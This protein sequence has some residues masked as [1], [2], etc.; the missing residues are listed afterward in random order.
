MTGGTAYRLPA[1]APVTSPILVHGIERFL[2]R[3][4]ELC[5]Y[6]I[7]QGAL[8]SLLLNW[9]YLWISFENGMLCGWIGVGQVT[10]D[11]LFQMTEKKFHFSIT[12]SVLSS[13][14]NVR[15]KVFRFMFT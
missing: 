5:V 7:A 3:K 14:P 12:L 15:K 13:V 8:E 2:Q 4:S 11:R 1:R 9:S 6:K 10:K